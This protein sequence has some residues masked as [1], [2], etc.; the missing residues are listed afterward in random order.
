M[1]VIDS[2]T[3]GEPTRVII[4]GGPDLGT[5]SMAERL[6]MMSQNYDYVRKSII[7]EPRGSDVLVGA[8]LCPP[9]DES[10][11]TGVIFFN[12]TGYLGMCGH[13]TI[14]VA[15]TLAHMG[16]VDSSEIKIETP[17]GIVSVNMQDKNTASVRN[18]PS[19]LY[20]E[21][22]SVDVEGLGTVTGD[23]AWGGN[24]FFLAHQSPLPVNLKNEPELLRSAKAIKQAL[25]DNGITGKDGA[26]IDHIE[27][28]DK[29]EL[30]GADSKNYVLCPGDAY[31]RSPCGTG[32]SAKVATLA[33]KGLLKEN[34][35]WVQD[36]IINSRFEAKYERN[37]NGEVIPTI[38]GSA[39]VHAETTILQDPNDPFKHGID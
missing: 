11:V 25:I 21:N 38:T 22:I 18:V 8:L 12:N 14:G 7:L 13:G 23:V 19:Y 36:S 9:T 33:A 29:P 1:K 31:D 35:I 3:G 20:Q 26:E 15:V 28:F 2:H 32:T 30:A 5:G 17:V 16:L 4:E 34:E 39:Y 24:W 10:C 27:F 6:N 37:E